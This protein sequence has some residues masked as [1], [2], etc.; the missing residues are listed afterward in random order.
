VPRM[1]T[2]PTSFT[3]VLVD[4]DGTIVDSA[5]GITATLAYTLRR[6]GLPVPPPSRL[7]EFVGPPIMD[8]FRDLAGLDPEQSVT[9]LGIYRERYAA[10]GAFDAEVY[11]GM[12][13]ALH[14]LRASGLPLALAT[15]KPENQAA[16]ILEHFGLIDL[17]TVVAGASDDERRSE[18]ADVIT[19]ALAQLDDA[20]VDRSLPVMVGDR[21]HDVEGAAAHGIG[22]VFAEWGYGSPAE[23]SGAIAV[24]PRPHDLASVVLRGE[25]TSTAA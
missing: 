9:A 2:T 21:I 10:R 17:F 18:K 6:M 14:A 13:E 15:S 20:G 12:P 8:G 19:W 7:L 4:L 22:T 3:V 25:G 23:A 11:P 16:R 24:A 5:R 1:L